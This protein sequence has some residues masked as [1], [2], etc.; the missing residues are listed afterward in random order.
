MAAGGAWPG[1]E[2]LQPLPGAGPAV[3][4]DASGT[5]CGNV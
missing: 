4:R 3:T 5:A 2:L 1:T